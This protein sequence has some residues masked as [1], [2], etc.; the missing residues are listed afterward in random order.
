VTVAVLATL[1]ADAKHAG[2]L[3]DALLRLADAARD[4]PGTELFVVHESAEHAGH[5]VVFERYRDD[6]AVAAHRGSPAMT[7]FRAA[8]RATGITPTV[9]FLTPLAGVGL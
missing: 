3:R 9:V 6:D 5:F 2:V 7:E 1:R 8:L 4:E